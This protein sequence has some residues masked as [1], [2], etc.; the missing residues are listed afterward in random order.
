[1]LFRELID[2]ANEETKT[3]LEKYMMFID[4]YSIEDLN[5][6]HNDFIKLFD[7][8]ESDL[9]IG[10]LL[11]IAIIYDKDLKNILNTYGNLK[12][13]FS[14]K[15]ER[16]IKS[17]DICYTSYVYE[18]AYNKEVEAS[19]LLKAYANFNG[20]ICIER[21]IHNIFHKISLIMSF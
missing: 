20:P 19:T 16:I 10:Y 6:I 17:T 14:K 12:I 13:P 9:L 1:M 2:R 18:Y 7:N 8:N 15:I 21:I 5:P 4:D 11:Y 3:I